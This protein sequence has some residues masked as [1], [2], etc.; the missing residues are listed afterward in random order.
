[1]AIEADSLKEIHPESTDF[2]TIFLC[3]SS[4]WQLAE[5][6]RKFEHNPQAGIHEDLWNYWKNNLQGVFKAEVV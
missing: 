1:M 5:L 3:L 4:T 2:V 6:T